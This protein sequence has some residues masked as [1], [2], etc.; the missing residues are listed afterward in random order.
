MKVLV[1]GGAGYIGSV[2]VAQLLETGHSVTV[3]DNLSNGHLK[4]VP[5]GAEVHV[6]EVGDR[7]LLDRLLPD[8]QAVLH[9][10]A[11][12]EVG[13]S[14]QSP[15][16]HFRNN[17]ANAFALF[18]A[19]L[20][21]DVKKFVYSSTAALYG[22]PSRVP[23]EESDPLQPTNAYGESKL[24]VEQALSWLHSQNGLA[25]ASLRY[26]NAAGGCAERGED[27]CPESHLIPIT[28]GVAQGKRPY[29]SIFGTDYPT[30]DGSAIRDYIHVED[31]ASAHLLALSALETRDKLIYNLGNGL[32]CTVR[33]VIA[34]VRKLTGH[35][36][37][38]QEAPRRE[39]DPAELVAS[40]EKIRRELGWTPRYPDLESIVSSAWVWHGTNPNGYSGRCRLE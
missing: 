4:A 27:H 1:T 19:M 35:P 40:S 9:F 26:F 7:D 21:H 5:S 36:V 24:M 30:R 14:M 2:V 29:V 31:L 32:G 22:N 13:E 15:V 12:I 17:A 23:I 20:D 25:Y 11:S 3:L 16:K 33:E 28:L 18:E 38:A 6:G 8:I 37:P 39:G 10:A 34:T